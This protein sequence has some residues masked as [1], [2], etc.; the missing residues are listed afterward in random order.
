M[1]ASNRNFEGKTATSR[2]R[3]KRNESYFDGVKKVKHNRGT[4]QI[5][6]GVWEGAE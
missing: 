2:T 3:L 1:L 5:K 4:R 6:R